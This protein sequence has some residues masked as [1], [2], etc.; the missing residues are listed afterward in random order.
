LMLIISKVSG[1]SDVTNN[2]RE[3]AKGFLDERTTK[4]DELQLDHC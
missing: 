1:V 4:S 2:S 3:L